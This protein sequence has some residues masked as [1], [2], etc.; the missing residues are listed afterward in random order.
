MIRF[1]YNGLFIL[2][3]LFSS[4][5]AAQVVPCELYT[6]RTVA[7]VD[8]DKFLPYQAPVG[9]KDTCV[10][11]DR[12]QAYKKSF[13]YEQKL[14]QAVRAA[15]GATVTGAGSLYV[16][17]QLKSGGRAPGAVAALQ[18]QPALTQLLTL[19]GAVAR[20]VGGTVANFVGYRFLEQSPFAT[21]LTDVV[22]QPPSLPWFIQTHT[23]WEQQVQDIISTSKDWADPD[24]RELIV[25]EAL[26]VL[27]MLFIQDLENI[28]G[29]MEYRKDMLK[30][31]QDLEYQRSNTLT[32]HIVRLC[33]KLNEQW[34]ML[35][36]ELDPAALQILVKNIE[37][38]LMRLKLEVNSFASL[39]KTVL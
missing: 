25:P 38:L 1:M 11:W 18:N 36:K 27:F 15:V 23:Q 21:W 17:G 39:E 37:N 33:E 3:A 16:L 34:N 8:V 6:N 31:A 20:A 29:Y 13:E 9:I 10:S 12:V 22:I 5:I 26:D 28:L 19:S 32:T 4:L 7:E 14:A 35:R 24:Y 2:F 30:E